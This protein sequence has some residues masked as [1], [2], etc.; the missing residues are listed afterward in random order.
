MTKQFTFCMKNI[1]PLEITFNGMEIYGKTFPALIMHRKK[2]GNT[3]RKTVY[4]TREQMHTVVLF[5]KEALW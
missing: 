5:M 3:V 4:V 2:Y 1:P